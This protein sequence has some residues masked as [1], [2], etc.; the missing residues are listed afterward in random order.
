MIINREGVN[1]AKNI[2]APTIKHDRIHVE[3]P[4]FNG[5]IPFTKKY[6]K[7]VDAKEKYETIDYAK[8]IILIP[9]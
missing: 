8:K 2:P 7:V 9:R 5:A 1:F 4:L 6:K 3:K